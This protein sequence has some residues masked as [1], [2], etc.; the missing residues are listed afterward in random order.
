[1]INVEMSPKPVAPVGLAQLSSSTIRTSSMSD[2]RFLVFKKR[3]W[4]RSNWLLLLQY[5]LICWIFLEAENNLRQ[6]VNFCVF[7]RK[8]W[9]RNISANHQGKHF[10]QKWTSLGA[11]KNWQTYFFLA[12]PFRIL[13]T[14]RFSI[15]QRRNTNFCFVKYLKGNF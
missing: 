5:E 13:S 14:Y 7:L 15:I 4:N 3:S 1:M 6:L 9:C 8:S 2:L 12:L 11:Q 10:L